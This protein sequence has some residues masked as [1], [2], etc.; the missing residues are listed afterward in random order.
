MIRWRILR[1]R[2]TSSRSMRGL[3]TTSG[4]C[5]VAELARVRV[6]TLSKGARTLASSATK[7]E[8][9]VHLINSELSVIALARCVLNLAAERA[10]FFGGHWG[11]VNSSWGA[12]ITRTDASGGA[13]L[14]QVV[15][16]RSFI[17][18]DLRC[19]GACV[20]TRFLFRLRSVWHRDCLLN[21]R[22]SFARGDALRVIA[23]SDQIFGDAHV[24]ILGT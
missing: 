12:K 18:L 13:F 5:K 21:F 19:A 11:L 20:A 8:L 17:C 2:S 1:A 23:I 6:V 7:T 16:C 24:R 22:R 14:E 3:Q 15:R 9:E 10:Q 4:H